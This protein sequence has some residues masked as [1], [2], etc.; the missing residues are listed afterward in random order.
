MLGIEPKFPTKPKLAAPPEL[1]RPQ[2]V[3]DIECYINCFIIAF[4][5]LSDGETFSMM[6]TDDPG[7]KLDVA[8]LVGIIRK[9]E[10]ISFNG[11]K[12]DVPLLRY[13]MTGADT[14]QLKAACDEL[15]VEKLSEWKFV[16]K[17]RCPELAGLDH[18]DVMDVAPL[19]ASRAAS[20]ARA[21]GT[22]RIRRRQGSRR[23]RWRTCASTASMIW[24]TPSCST[25]SC[26]LRSSCDGHWV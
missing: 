20:T 19:K 1:K 24:T 12:F 11:N 17:Y 5:R 13:T 7:S 26:H 4:K 18:I 25:R 14:A 23:S 8:A 3:F 2:A 6:M 15:I 10:L 16:S 22:F 9:Y 21:S